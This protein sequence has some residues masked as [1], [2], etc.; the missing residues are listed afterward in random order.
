MAAVDWVI[1]T[2]G[3]EPCR[4]IVLAT[5]APAVPLPVKSLVHVPNPDVAQMVFDDPPAVY[6]T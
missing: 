2:A 1:E 3:N 4:V 6:L 5:T